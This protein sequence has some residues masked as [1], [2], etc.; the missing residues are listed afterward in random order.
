MTEVTPTRANSSTAIAVDGRPT[1]DEHRGSVSAAMN[2]ITQTAAL[3]GL[4]LGPL[5]G[6]LLG[7]RGALVAMGATT[8]L[9]SGVLA[10]RLARVVAG[11]D[12]EIRT[13]SEISA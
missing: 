6:D 13:S 3:V 10:V 9:L 2:G 1:P 5:L 8:V 12:S 7:I 11:E 4:P